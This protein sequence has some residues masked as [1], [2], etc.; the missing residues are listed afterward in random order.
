MFNLIYAFPELFLLCLASTFIVLS[1]RK[2]FF[3][4]FIG[5][6]LYYCIIILPVVFWGLA[7]GSVINDAY[8]RLD[9]F[10]QIEKEGLLEEARLNPSSY[11]TML[12]IDLKQFSSGEEFKVYIH[13]S[14]EKGVDQAE[15]I[16]IG[17]LFAVISEL[18]TL[19]VHAF[20]SLFLRRRKKN[21]N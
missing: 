14:Y 5:S 18:S 2:I 12:Q 20:K 1:L 8:K 6:C 19:C 11:D 13:D 16:S 9:L 3:K 7:G 15:F 21:G 4:G 17:L 10:V